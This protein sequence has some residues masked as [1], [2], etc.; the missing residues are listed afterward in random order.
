MSVLLPRRRPMKGNT[1][2]T[3]RKWA[4]IFLAAGVIGRC[5]IQNVLLSVGTITSDQLFE[6]MNADTTVMILA[7]VALICEALETCAAPLFA[8]LLVEGFQRTSSFEKYLIRIGGMALLCEIP[9]NMAYSR[10]LLDLGSRNPMI[11]MLICLVMLYFFTRFGDK[12]IRNTVIKAVIAVAAFLWCTM[13]NVDSGE[14][15]VILVGVLWLVREKDN[16]RALYGFC[17]GMACSMFNMYYIASCLSFIFLHRYEGEQGEENKRLNYA[18]YPVL[19]LIVGTAA[20][21]LG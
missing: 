17:A 19:L 3:I 9:Y 10:S 6:A 4:M 16:M 18:F 2:A 21:L 8:F 13:L 1:C 12:G 14:C 5:I 20:I 11:G 7:T 15:L